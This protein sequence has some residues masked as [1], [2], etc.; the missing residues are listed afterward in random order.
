M[1]VRKIEVKKL[2]IKSLFKVTAYMMIVPLGIFFL[3]G[4]ATLIIG[5]AIGQPE[6]R[7]FG[8]IYMIFPIFMIPLYGGIAALTGLIY[9]AFSKKFGGLECYIEDEENKFIL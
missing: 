1:Y 4:L 6:V 5:S 3:I 9:N 8:I 2:G 7:I